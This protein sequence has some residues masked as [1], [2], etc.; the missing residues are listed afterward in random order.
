ML[1]SITLAEKLYALNQAGELSRALERNK[2]EVLL[3][4]RRGVDGASGLRRWLLLGYQYNR[5]TSVYKDLGLGDLKDY[6]RGCAYD[7]I[8]GEASFLAGED[9]SSFDA[10][11]LGGNGG[12]EVLRAFEEAGLSIV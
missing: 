9:Y 2:L 7:N 10:Y 5:L 4:Y 8:K 11:L 6:M 12:G 3:V 1:D